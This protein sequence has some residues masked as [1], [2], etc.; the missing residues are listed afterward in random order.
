MICIGFGM[1]YMPIYIVILTTTSSS[2]L[3]VSF[4]SARDQSEL[5][6]IGHSIFRRRGFTLV[7]HKWRLLLSHMLCKFTSVFL[8]S[9]YPF[10]YGN[11]DFFF[12]FFFK[13][14]VKSYSGYRILTQ[15]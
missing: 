3:E 5:L 6:L 13:R 11:S 8:S 15:Y 2:S 4:R 9:F 1:C 14:I 12:S 10:I 7:S